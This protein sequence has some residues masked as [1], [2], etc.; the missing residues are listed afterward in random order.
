[1]KTMSSW[2]SLFVAAA[3]TLLSLGAAAQATSADPAMRPNAAASPPDDA[4]AAMQRQ[5]LALARA[6]ST[7]VGLRAIAVDDAVSNRTLGRQRAGSGVLIDDDG[8]LILTIGYLVMEAEQVEVE[9][10]D[11]RVFPARV[12][13]YDPA[14]GFGLVRSLTP[15]PRPAT[16]LG[17]V[18]AL[19]PNE[20]MM[21]VSGGADGDLGVAYLAAQRPFTG[22]WEYHLDNALYTT[23]PR[24]DHSGAGL[25][26]AAGELV[27]IG[28]LL[29]RDARGPG[30]A[31][32]AGNLF[33]PVDLLKPILAELRDNGRSAA[34]RRAWLGVNC[35]E[36]D[37]AVRVTRVTTDSPADAAG[38]QPGDQ[39]VAIDATPVD[40]LLGFYRRLW[41][42]STP[43][44]E[45]RLDIRRDGSVQT[46]RVQATD[47][48]YSLRHAQGI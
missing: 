43:N 25:F 29:V 39:I 21:V 36:T 2:R 27:G 33:V 6:S 5:T 19:A 38:L 4:D 9:L 14:S 26:N 48:L 37:G 40:S 3:A 45:V 31:P 12:V 47:R 10:D 28:A 11:G 23:P 46:V 34:S 7:V 17:S 16:T 41:D 24:P 44:R 20:P 13:A 8:S 35:L 32:Q 18:A 1:M 42:G 15:L 22:Y 30:Q